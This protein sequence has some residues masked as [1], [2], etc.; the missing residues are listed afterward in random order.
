MCLALGIDI[1]GTKYPLVL[2]TTM[3]SQMALCGDNA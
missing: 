3:L 1:E 2:A